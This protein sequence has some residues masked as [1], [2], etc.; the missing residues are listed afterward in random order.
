[1]QYLNPLFESQINLIPSPALLMAGKHIPSVS[2]SSTAL[3][4]THTHTHTQILDDGEIIHD[5]SR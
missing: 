4:R 1:M 2:N 3:G 5:I